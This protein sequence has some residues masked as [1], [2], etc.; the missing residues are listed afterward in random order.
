MSTIAEDDAAK[1]KLD[2]GPNL[3]I[4]DPAIEEMMEVRKTFAPFF[5]CMMIGLFFIIVAAV[6]VTIVVIFNQRIEP[7]EKALTV[8]L[9][10][11]SLGMILGHSAIFFGVVMSWLG[12]AAPFKMGL[13]GESVGAKGAFTIVSASPGLVLLAGGLVL[14]GV[15]LYKPIL[16]RETIEPPDTVISPKEKRPP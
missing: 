16:Y 8:Q 10:Q 14:I 2:Q 4:R 13:K 6:V 9:V 3:D 1:Q 7:A 5:K 11:V 15:S 12:I